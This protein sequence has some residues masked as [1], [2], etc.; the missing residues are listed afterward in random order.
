VITDNVKTKVLGTSFLVSRD[1]LNNIK[2]SVLTGKV[3]VSR[4]D[5]LIRLLLPSDQLTVNQTDGG[6]QYTTV[7]VND[8]VLWKQ[9]QHVLREQ[10]IASIAAY[11]GG[12]QNTNINI[13]PLLNRNKDKYTL[14]FFDGSSLDTIMEMIET[15]APNVKTEKVN[16]S[17]WT[18]KVDTR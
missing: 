9:G 12:Y 8:I 2:V 11:L 18:W 3:S 16:S 15:V 7:P 4:N 1:H 10:T 14:I 5:L 6:H 13:D 17:T